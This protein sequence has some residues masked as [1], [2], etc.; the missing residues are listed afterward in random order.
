[1]LRRR[2][3]ERRGAGSQRDVRLGHRGRRHGSRSSTALDATATQRRHRPAPARAARRRHAS[4]PVAAAEAARRGPATGRRAAGARRRRSGQRTATGGAGPRRRGRDGS[5]RGGAA[6][7]RPAGAADEPSGSIGAGRSRIRQHVTEIRYEHSSP[8]DSTAGH[9]VHDQLRSSSLLGGISLTRLP[10]DLM[11]DFEQP[12]A[13]PS[14][15]TT[16][17]VGPLEMEELITRPIEQAVSAVA[18][19]DA[20]RID[21]VGRQQPT[22]A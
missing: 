1:M 8:R 18:G 17:G 2:T 14:A 20:R 13:S 9:D 15:S 22:S 10:V 4:V 11:P 3:S 19:L 6:G 21:L 12:H 7:S 5:D 16:P